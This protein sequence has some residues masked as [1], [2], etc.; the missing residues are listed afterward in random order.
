[1]LKESIRG[2]FEHLLSL[3]PPMCP[4]IARH[5]KHSPL[6]SI[7]FLHEPESSHDVLVVVQK[8]SN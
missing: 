4:V 6:V 2:E 5:S 8:W 7:F 1:M 3:L